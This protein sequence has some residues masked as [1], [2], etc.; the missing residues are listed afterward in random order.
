MS[1]PPSF[2]DAKKKVAFAWNS[3]KDTLE[4]AGLVAQKAR[5]AKQKSGDETMNS[6]DYN[7]EYR[8]FP[9][10][11][12]AFAEPDRPVNSDFHA[13]YEDWKQ[14]SSTGQTLE[15]GNESH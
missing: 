10:H 11:G 6:G 1:Y 9:G 13:G 8:L 15:N 3:A 5:Q 12:F 7:K 4:N 14:L 2:E